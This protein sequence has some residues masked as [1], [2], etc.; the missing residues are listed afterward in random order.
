MHNDCG[1]VNVKFNHS[2]FLTSI[3]NINLC[4]KLMFSILIIFFYKRTT[5]FKYSKIPMVD[6][7]KSV[8]II[9]TDQE[10]K[11]LW[12]EKGKLTWKEHLIKNE[13]T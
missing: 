11:K 3:L 9:L 13:V 12:K 4:I 6:T 10:H 2:Y 5:K 7:M 1:F 8:H